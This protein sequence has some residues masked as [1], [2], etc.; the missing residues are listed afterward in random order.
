MMKKDILSLFLLQSCGNE[1]IRQWRLH[2][3]KPFSIIWLILPLR[4]SQPQKDGCHTHH[5]RLVYDISIS[6]NTKLVKLPT[7][8]KRKMFQLQPTH[9]PISNNLKRVNMFLWGRREV[10]Y[11]MNGSSIT[12]NINTFYSRLIT[13]LTNEYTNP[14][15]NQ[16]I[17]LDK[18]TFSFT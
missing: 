18:L 12:R 11:S 3:S 8:T 15:L 4:S 9:I 7:Q 17:I 1:S 16:I 2:E 5:L 14:L 6:T 13:N 10:N